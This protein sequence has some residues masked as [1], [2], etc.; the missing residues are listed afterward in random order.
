VR[1]GD[2]Y[3]LR[4][5]RGGYLVDGGAPENE[6]P[7][8]LIDRK[9]NRLRAAV[10][11]SVCPER[12]GGIL[13][14]MEAG[15]PVAEYWLPDRLEVLPEL[16][17]RFNGDWGAWLALL[18][19][20]DRRGGNDHD[21][22]RDG[23]E[24]LP[25]DDFRRRLEGAALLIGLAMTACLGWS[26]YSGMSRRA[27]LG[28]DSADPCSGLIRFFGR[29]LGVLSDRAAVRRRND[30]GVVNRILR[31]AGW[32]FFSGGSLED[33]A[34]LCC[35]FLHAEAE[36]L[37]GGNGRG[38]RA[39][40]CG[41]TMA[42]MAAIRMAKNES[43]FRFF[44]QTGKLEDHFVPRHPLKCLNGVEIIRLPELVPVST[45]EM[46]FKETRRMVGQSE[47]L[48]FQY[49]DAQCGVLF[50]GDT[51]MAFLGRGQSLTLDR[52]T[53]I[54]APRQGNSSSDQAYARIV[55]RNSSR[56][57]WVRSHFSHARKV[58]GCFK[59][60]PEKFCLNNC[61]HHTVHEI[62]LCYSDD[63]WNRKTDGSCFCS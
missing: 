7:E 10:C 19:V 14:L 35:R 42:A 40:V 36:M 11:S 62:L 1:R 58:S 21:G 56:D 17:R 13:D 59:E 55:S 32:C 4:S 30:D 27:V 20:S 50:C 31:R 52:P 28:G 57:I 60:K 2:A 41:L 46:I 45:P 12:L 51:E 37:P 3:L 16:A 44:R 18:G 39:V 26:P 29:T 15:H 5:R 6:L 33:I 38:I 22:W 23:V 54:A 9:V 34:L 49:G 48:A 63:R 61:F 47:G 24:L 43:C 53:V 25:D 8:M